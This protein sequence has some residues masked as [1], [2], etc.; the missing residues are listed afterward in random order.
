[1]SQRVWTRR[2]EAL[3]DRHLE[4]QLIELASKVG[5]TVETADGPKLLFCSNDYLGL[6][7]SPPIRE[8]LKK[9]VDSWGA[10]SASSRLVSGHT[11]AHRA[12]EKKIANQL[13][14]EDAVLFSSGYHANVG[15][16]PCLTQAGD[17][18]FS[19]ALSHAS[20]IDGC[21]LSRADIHVYR[22]CDVDHLDR[23][24]Q[25]HPSDG[26]RLIVTDALFSMDGDFAPLGELIEVAERHDALIY[27][28]EAHS[29]GI[30]GPEGR[31]L[32]AA[33]SETGRIAARVITLGKAAG[34]VGAV[35]ATDATPAALLRSS[36]RSLLYTTALPAALASAA[37]TAIDQVIAAEGPRGA[38]R[39]NI[40]YLRERLENTALGGH[41]SSSP[42]QP[43]IVGPADR[44]MAL[45]GRLYDEGILVQG[46]RPPTVPEDSSRLRI[47][48]SAFHNQSHLDQ[49]IDT[50]E[51]SWQEFAQP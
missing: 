13:G 3:R 26:M 15:A 23:L 43:I 6:A 46:I 25:Q 48:L 38:L 9:A 30:I 39:E 4:R 21:R 28:D 42:I 7:A 12:V 20:I 8:A 14:S 11:S 41:L 10:G 27:L 22:H 35:V 19:D 24:L 36:A 50:L 33:L 44:T 37:T 34:L 32:G 40:R 1:M 45:S 18:I 16:L 5:P 47:T 49:L 17:H 29:F 2:L 31:G 51:R